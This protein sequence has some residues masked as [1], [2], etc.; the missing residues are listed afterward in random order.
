[1]LWGGGGIQLGE[2]GGRMKTGGESRLDDCYANDLT[3]NGSFL[4]LVVWVVREA[5]YFFIFFPRAS[6]WNDFLYFS[7]N[8]WRIMQRK[9]LPGNSPSVEMRPREE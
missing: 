3:K 9:T 4:C 1:M 8:S 2:R 7:C 6:R 5:V